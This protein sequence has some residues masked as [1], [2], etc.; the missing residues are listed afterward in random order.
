M[1]FFMEEGCQRRMGCDVA[2]TVDEEVE[3]VSI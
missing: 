2:V 1:L 3:I